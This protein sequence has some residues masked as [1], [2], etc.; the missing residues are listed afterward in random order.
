MSDKRNLVIKFLFA[1]L[2]EK[3]RGLRR[4]DYLCRK[5]EPMAETMIEPEK[6]SYKVSLRIQ[7]RFS[8]LD[9]VN[10]VNNSFQ[11][12]YY[13]LGRID[14]FEKVMGRELDWSKLVVVI[15]HT[16]NNFFSPIVQGEE[17]FVESKVVKFGNR[18]MTM[19]QRLVNSQGMVKGTC[20]TILAG[21]DR[22]SNLSAPIEE[23]F[24]RR[25][26]EFEAEK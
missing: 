23:D 2:R 13:D 24:K 14:Y 17:I 18:S 3:G 21:F 16:E 7:V 6:D 4:I 20:R 15:V 25:F 1:A 22:S 12:Q 10:H 26:L 19:N 5:F 8:D 11:F 9:P